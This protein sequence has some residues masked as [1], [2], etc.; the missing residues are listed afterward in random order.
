MM[1]ELVEFDGGLEGI[2]FETLKKITSGVFLLGP[3]KS[4]GEGDTG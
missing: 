2:V 4:V 3:S 1:A